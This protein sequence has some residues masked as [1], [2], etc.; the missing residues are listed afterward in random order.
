[1]H[2][3]ITAFVAFSALLVASAGAAQLS[4]TASLDG[5]AA[6]TLT[7]STATGTANV[8]V[9]TDAQTV[10]VHMRI[11][12]VSLD[13]LWD[14]VIHSGMGPVHLHLYAANGDISLLVPFPYGGAYAATPD[15]FS[16]DVDNYSYT[17][18]AAL[19]HSDMSFDTFVRTLGSDFVYLNIHT[20]AYQDGE[21]SGRLRPQG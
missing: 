8:S 1:M 6:P 2:R 15:G 20:D 16:L 7:G 18:G 10:S 11:H 17:T 5:A 12:G 4:Y 13:Q 21:I 14:H 19:L 9:D 3:F